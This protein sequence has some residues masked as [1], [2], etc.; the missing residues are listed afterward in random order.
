MT[1]LQ[2]FPGRALIP[3]W[4][5]AG[6]A[7]LAVVLAGWLVMDRLNQLTAWWPWSD[8]SKL[9]RSE[10]RI[11][12]LEGRLATA[13][14]DAAWRA[15]EADGNADQL[16]RV[17]TVHT[18]VIE[19]RTATAAAETEARNIPDA[20]TPLAPVR[21]GLLRGHDGRLCV[22]AGGL[23]DCPRAAPAGDPGAGAEA[24]PSAGAAGEP[25]AG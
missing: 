1:G 24:V 6:G 8:E 13:R 23:P 11:E 15:A 21:A 10:A 9:E 12:D 25:D 18:Q 19:I 22:Q 14:L 4:V 3:W 5:K 7:A 16:R 20:E 17:E 2:I